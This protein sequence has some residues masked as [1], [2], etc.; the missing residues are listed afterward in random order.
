MNLQNEFSKYDIALSTDACEDDLADIFCD[1]IMTSM[2]KKNTPK[3][4]A[5][6]FAAQKE[7]YGTIK[8]L[9]YYNESVPLNSF[10][11]PNDLLLPDGTRKNA[12]RCLLG[13]TDKRMII[14]GTGGLGKSVLMRYMTLKLM[15]EYKH[16]KK[17]PVMVQLNE[18]DSKKLPFTEV[19]TEN[20]RSISDWQQ[21]LI[22]GDC[23]F[24]LDAMDE[25]PTEEQKRFEKEL[26][27][28]VSLYPK[29]TY[30]MSSRPISRFIQF[31]SFKTYELAPFT[32]EQ[33]VAMVRKVRYHEDTPSLK[34]KFILDLQDELYEQHQDFV[35]NPLL[36]TIMLLTYQFHAHIPKKRHVFFA[37]AFQTLAK[38]H[39]E[40]KEGFDR[41]FETKM[42]PREF[43]MIL[44]EFCA[45]TYLNEKFEFTDEEF[46]SIYDKLDVIHRIDALY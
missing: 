8:N 3:A 6:H 19:I 34:G 35:E 38:N 1:I 27:K 15:D 28:Y 10:Y 5:L 23:I 40:T 11:V 26:L 17:I 37:E 41:V 4:L 44:Q 25:I 16:Y 36:L 42:N 14:S 12:A 22:N 45:R 20:T 18:Y 46:Y 32:L 43:S 9:L 31:Q 7:R 29:N 2:E 24:L 39:D 21:H 30:I 13:G 33:A